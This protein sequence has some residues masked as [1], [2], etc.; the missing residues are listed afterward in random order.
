MNEK[1]VKQPPGCLRQHGEPM[2][3][4][5][6][7]MLLYLVDRRAFIESGYPLTGD[8]FVSAADGPTLRTLSSL[9][10]GDDGLTGNEWSTYVERVGTDRL[11]HTQVED[12][13]ALSERDCMRLGEILDKHQSMPCS[14]ISRKIRHLPEWQAPTEMFEPLDPVVLLRDAGSSNE[15][16]EEVVGLVGSIHWL[17]TTLGQ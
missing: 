1:P 8:D 5:R 17:H 4:D 11:T 16:I 3:A 14:L 15:E 7:I 9:M 10:F 6:L 13:G 2:E 12:V